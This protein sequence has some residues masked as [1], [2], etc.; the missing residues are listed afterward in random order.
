[1]STDTF[2]T[3]TWL[4]DEMIHCAM[5]AME[6][7][8]A[9]IALDPSAGTGRLLRTMKPH[10]DRLLAVESNPDMRSAL[11]AWATPTD[12]HIADFMRWTFREGGIG[13]IL[14]SPPPLR[15]T[16]HIARAYFALKPGGVLVALAPRAYVKASSKQ[17]RALLQL[18]NLKGKSFGLPD[19]AFEASGVTYVAEMVQIRK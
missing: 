14:M 13:L 4:A 7:P 12:V 3:P 17:D 10:A 19:N 6:E 1:V 8:R 9:A 2:D 5:R 18:V 16:E 11:E 15:A